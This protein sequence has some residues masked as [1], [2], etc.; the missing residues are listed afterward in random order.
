[1][2]C[3]SDDFVSM[4]LNRW[5]QWLGK[6]SGKPNI[7]G[8][9]IGSHEG[10]SAAW[11]AQNILTHESSTLTCIDPWVAPVFY[12]NIAPD[13][14]KIRCIAKASQVALRDG[15][16]VAESYHFVYIDGDHRAP[17]VLQDAVLAFPLLVR[18]GIMILDDYAWRSSS[19]DVPQSMPKVAIDAFVTVFSEQLRVLYSGWQFALEKL[20]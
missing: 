2:P 6:F 20:S 8:L 7:K 12:S 18:G 15:S 11:F 9:E 1:M 4:H 5:H 10:R 16:F 14:R 19:P 13:A 17:Q 3:F